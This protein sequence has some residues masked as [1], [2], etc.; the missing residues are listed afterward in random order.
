MEEL[1][2]DLPTY[3]YVFLSTLV[4]FSAFGFLL[5][6]QA[7]RFIDLSTTDPL[8]GLRN[9][10]VLYERLEGEIARAHRY[11]QPLSL[12]I[13]DV[14]RLKEINDQDGHRAG[15]AALRRVAAARRRGARSADLGARWG[16]DEFA[17][18]AP[19]TTAAAASGLAERVRLLVMEGTGAAPSGRVTISVGVATVEPSGPLPTPE[20]LVLHADEALYAA[21]RAGRNRVVGTGWGREGDA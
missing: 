11:A 19:N 3:L 4:A 10:R 7:D 9:R 21:K 8:T 16:G 20:L 12:L 14:D 6:R 15:D 1:M 17:L 13:I 2:A 18:L 5:G